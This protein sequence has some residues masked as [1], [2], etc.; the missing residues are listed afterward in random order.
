MK[1]L[2]IRFILAGLVAGFTYLA[3]LSNTPDSSSNHHS[4]A[5]TTFMELLAQ[6][7]QGGGDSVMVTTQE[8]HVRKLNYAKFRKSLLKHRSIYYAQD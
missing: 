6:S 1:N 3:F 2:P 7:A 4:T 5:H 8:E